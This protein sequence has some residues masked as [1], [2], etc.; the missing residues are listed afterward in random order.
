MA[1]RPRGYR[2][3]RIGR[4]G[5]SQQQMEDDMA[6]TYFHV[7]SFLSGQ[8]MHWGRFDTAA[9]AKAMQAAKHAHGYY[10]VPIIECGEILDNSKIV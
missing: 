9:E 8:I 2:G 10:Y 5:L 4:W 3:G 1:S 6:K 7:I